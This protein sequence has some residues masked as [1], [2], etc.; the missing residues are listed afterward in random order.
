M[1]A[2]NSS[3]D[4][5]ATPARVYTG[6]FAEQGTKASGF[7]SDGPY[8]C[9]DCIHYMEAARRQKR[10]VAQDDDSMRGDSA[11]RGF[12]G[13][14]YHPAVMN[15]PNLPDMPD[16]TPAEERKQDDGGIRVDEE[17]EC[18]R[19]VHPPETLH[20]ADSDKD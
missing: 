3:L 12:T 14:C 15:D 9:E 5:L 18:C 11:P 13:A 17:R 7:A 16:G 20:A 2:N 19:F 4:G 10:P 8:H 6:K 1:N